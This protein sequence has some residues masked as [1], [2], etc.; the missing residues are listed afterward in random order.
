VRFQTGRVPQSYLAQF[1]SVTFFLH[2]DEGIFRKEGDLW[3]VSI[4][5]A[6]T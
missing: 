3:E 2:K 1:K 6:A 5:R 4:W